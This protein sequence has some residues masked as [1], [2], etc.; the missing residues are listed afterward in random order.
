MPVNN[1][2]GHEDFRAFAVSI[3]PAREHPPAHRG[4]ID[5]GAAQIHGDDA[6]RVRDV[7][8]RV[9]VEDDEVGALAGGERARR[10]SSAGTRAALRVAAT[11]TCIGVMPAA[12]M[13]AI[14]TCAAHGVLP[15]V[16]SAIFTPAPFSF[17]RLRAWIPKA[18]GLPADRSRLPAAS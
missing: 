1:H 4:P 2:E 18:P 3:R 14:S 17:A 7:V 9:G 12:T 8:Q 6:A 11:I 16:P 10:R 15:S 5:G 13:S